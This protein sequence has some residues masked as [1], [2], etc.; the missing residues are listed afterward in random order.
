MPSKKETSDIE[1]LIFRPSKVSWGVQN[2]IIKLNP[3]VERLTLIAII[4]IFLLALLW[5]HLSIKAVVV[6]TSGEI[7]PVAS[8]IP[9]IALGQMTIKEIKVRD[10]QQLNKDDIVLLST[11]YLDKSRILKIESIFHDLK[12]IVANEKS[13]GCFEAC[14][15][16]LGYLTEGGFGFIQEI[17][18]TS[19]FYRE[20]VD[21]SKL[22]KDFY[23]QLK[24]IRNLPETLSGLR[25]ELRITNKRISQIELRK[26]QNILALEYEELQNKQISLTAQLKEKELSSKAMIDTVRSSLEIGIDKIDQSFKNYQQNSV[27]KAPTTGRI[28][29]SSIKGVGQTVGGGE[30]LFMITQ[31][32]SDLW[33]KF[34]VAEADLGKVKTKQEVKLDLASYP[35]SEYGVQKGV[36]VEVLD[37]L[38]ADNDQSRTPSFFGYARLNSQSVKFRGSEYNLRSGMQA[39]VKIIVKHESLLK[40]FI[41]KIF[42]IKDEYIGEI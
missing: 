14:L 5:S 33:L 40:L 4:S 3:K 35:A 19:D 8:P 24:T 37:K 38:T 20:L 32:S 21:L 26:A 29:F 30:V 11:R 6:D 42:S 23:L 28:R 13:S 39:K 18:Q 27:I 34:S 1:A 17:Q 25:N 9:V 12:K 15:A 41:K 36:I 22:S 10:N 7:V 2:A 16:E 31:S